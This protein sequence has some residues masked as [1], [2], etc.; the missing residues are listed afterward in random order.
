MMVKKVCIAIAL[1]MLMNI[2]I[3]QAQW[4]Q[5]NGPYGGRLYSILVNGSDV[6]AGAYGAGVFR[7]TNNGAS[8]TAVNSGLTSFSLRVIMVN[9]SS[10]FA[11]TDGGAFRSTNNG[12]TWTQVNSGLAN[13]V[14]ALI[15]T[16][17]NLCAGTY[18][19]GVFLST[20]NGG[21]WT[22]INNG[23][24]NLNV[25]SLTMI[26]TNLFAGTL[27]GGVFLSTNNG[28]D[29]ATVNTG[30]TNQQIR[31]F[32]VVGSNLF[33]GTD[34]GGVFLS[35]NNGSSWTAVNSGLTATT[36]YALSASGSNIFA[37]VSNN[38]VFLSTN[39]G[40][41]WTAAN[42]GLGTKSVLA[43][44][45]SGATVFAGTGSGIFRSIDNGATWT[46]ANSGVMGIQV[47][48]LYK[49]GTTLF[50]GTEGNGA[51]LSTNNGADWS[52]A[53]TS[54]TSNIVRT[55]AET[56]GNLFA[57]TNGCV[58]RSTN[59]GA[60]WIELDARTLFTGINKL[61]VIGG[62]LFAGTWA[63][64]MFISTNNDVAIIG[65]DLFAATEGGG[66][67]RSTNNGT[68]WTAIN[69]GITSSYVER[70]AV[71]G[72]NLY[73]APSQIYLS[74]DNGAVWNKLSTGPMAVYAMYC[75][76]AN[77]FAGNNGGGI[78]LSTDNGANWTTVNTGLGNFSV[79]ALTVG[80]TVLYAG[81]QGG[82]WRRPLREMIPALGIP[83][84]IAPANSATNQA[85][86][87]SLS[88]NAMAGALTYCAQLSTSSD[89]NPLLVDDSSLTATSKAVGP[90][91]N[92]KTY[93]WRVRTK[94]AVGSCGWS[95]TWSFT[96]LPAAPDVPTLSTPENA[97]AN[98]TLSPSLAWSASSRAVT[99][100][101][102]L[103]SATNF[104]PLLVDDSALTSTSK[105]VGPLAN[106][107]TYF[108]RVRAKNSAGNSDW[109]ATWSFS[110][111]PPSAGALDLFSPGNGAVDQAI[112]PSLTWNAVTS[113]ST[114]C[115]QLSNASNF[116]PLLVDDSSLTTTVK[117]VGPL[118]NGTTYFW[119]VRA[120]NAAGTGPWSATW[121]FVTIPSLPG[122]AALVSPLA[123]AIITV[124]SAALLWNKAS[125]AP[126]RYDLEVYADSLK[127]VLVVSDT[128]IT[129]TTKTLKGL[130]NKMSFWWCVK[131]HNR[132]GW[133]DF[134][135]VR[136]LSVK[137]PTVGVK[138]T[139]YSCGISAS[140]KTGALITYGLPAA[141]RVAIELYNIQGKH[142]KTLL[143]ANKKPGYY[144]FLTDVGGF[145]KGYL[146]VS[147]KAGGFVSV[148]RIANF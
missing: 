121:S 53:N 142:L 147:F 75:C 114:Y 108:W 116:T 96:T 32:A 44:G 80:D 35:T 8:W 122:V 97:A 98:Q 40:A 140:I 34:G 68:G 54:L 49:T 5:T 82:V 105:A 103:S 84:L 65:T 12:G 13:N 131:A 76:G 60:D 109:S 110:T 36:V 67:F 111:L 132:A 81:T 71:S 78:Y 72:S 52:D 144:R 9:G 90:L 10:L 115:V 20:N 135:E 119:R 29:W 18:G 73:A 136:K 15:S 143:S 74:T 55:F 21:N 92:D 24:T 23:L 27:G 100:C 118:A 47:S 2:R 25:W 77:I 56:G 63:D 91:E 45:I 11:G 28:T 48:A 137:V 128:S 127:S 62:T 85:L 51:Y 86:R 139:K 69:S 134:G 133:G 89:F 17:S 7:S 59:S 43:I 16:G 129:D 101:V 87:S 22:A 61:A 112:S 99:Y 58:F 93:Y 64:G 6:W 31:A 102:Q 33:A 130:E 88:W 145:S 14:R 66:I 26:G 107:A 146:I 30:L 19:G 83:T 94:D 126:D 38:G 148:R 123:A 141:S 104:D 138:P 3:A 106:S 41:S 50:A 124:D 37:G 70:L 46:A 120:K 79:W 39:N 57:G 113:A 125:S 1:G 95:A 42:F 4:V 117:A